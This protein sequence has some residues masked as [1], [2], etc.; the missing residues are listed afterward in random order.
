MDEMSWREQRF[1]LWDASAVAVLAFHEVYV[2]LAVF[3]IEGGVHF[4]N[5]KTAVG[6]ARMTGRAGGTGLHPVLG[7]AGE[8]T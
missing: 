5:R 3:V 2:V 7:M 8:T 1:S 6:E 4:F